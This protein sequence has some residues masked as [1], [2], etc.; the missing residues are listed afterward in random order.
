MPLVFSSFCPHPPVIV[1]E[2]GKTELKKVEK[3]RRALKLLNTK[4]VQTKPQ[5]II[6][7][8]PHAP[9]FPDFFAISET[10]TFSG[11]L[12]AF[13][14]FKNYFEFKNDHAIKELIHEEAKISKIPCQLISNSKLDHGALVPL[15][16]L[17][18]PHASKLMLLSFSYHP[19]KIHFEFGRLIQKVIKKS[20]KR[21]AVLASGDLSHRLTDEAPAGFHPDGKRFDE[22]LIKL[23][24]EK[25]IKEIINLDQEFIENAGECGLRS[26]VILLGI[27]DKSDYHVEILSYEGPFGVGYLSV[28]FQI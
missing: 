2:I 12:S 1:P 19:L 14:D 13:G 5:T 7:I 18:P 28:N 10:N 17:R 4:F 20:D 11:D 16:F 9:L 23:L 21:V 8:S 15:H 26:L 22:K 24:K 6:L 25:K 27:L 3:T